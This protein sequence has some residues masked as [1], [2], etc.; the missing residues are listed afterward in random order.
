MTVVLRQLTEN[1]EQAFFDGMKLWKPDDISWYT[2]AWEDGMTYSQMLEILR[3]EVSGI[4][5]APGRVPHTM[6]YGFLDNQIIGRVSVRHKLND[7]LRH[8]GG[9]IGYSV[10]EPFRGKGYATHMVRQA[11]AYCKSLNIESVLV[12]CADDN[13]ASW[14][15]IERVGGE[16]QDRVW[17]DEDDELIRRYWIVLR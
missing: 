7:N 13:M 11:L 14:K 2:F 8:R 4:A 15:I 6:L 5:L 3:N 17:D 12:T 10:A 16:L 1:D 9:H